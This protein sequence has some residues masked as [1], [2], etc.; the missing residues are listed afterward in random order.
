MVHGRFSG[1]GMPAPW[2][3]VDS[4]QIENGVLAELRDVI[5]DAAVIE[6]SESGRIDRRKLDSIRCGV[7][8]PKRVKVKSHALVEERL[9]GRSATLP[10]DRTTRG[11][12]R[13]SE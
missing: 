10:P 7:V 9:P 5:E 6:M 1:F 13:R 12:V 2:I 11:V 3:V 8:G 4:V